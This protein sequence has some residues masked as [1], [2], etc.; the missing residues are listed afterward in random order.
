MPLAKAGD[1]ELSYDRAGDGPPLLLI[2][3]MSGT[4]HHWG[5]R[6][7]EELRKTAGASAPHA[8]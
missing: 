3:G 4:K 1:I 8:K 5:E 2:M 7:L 6:V